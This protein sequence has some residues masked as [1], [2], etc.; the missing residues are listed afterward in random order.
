[1]LL[2]LGRTGLPMGNAG[3]ASAIVSEGRA[4]KG[5]TPEHRFLVLV[6]PKK[7]AEIGWQCAFRLVFGQRFLNVECRTSPLDLHSECF[8]TKG[9][10]AFPTLCLLARDCYVDA[11]DAVFDLAASGYGGST[12]GLSWLLLVYEPLEQHTPAS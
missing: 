5:N 8:A 3:L 9:A 10:M 7:F 12:V 2:A 6:R 1:M 4:D 11:F